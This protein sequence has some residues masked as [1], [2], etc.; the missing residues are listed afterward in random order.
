MN[1][2][3]IDTIYRQLFVYSVGFYSTITE[4]ATK[5]NAEYKAVAGLWKVFAILL[6][7]CCHIDYQMVVSAIEVENRLELE[8]QKEQ[9]GK[10]IAEVENAMEEAQKVAQ[11]M[12]DKMEFV[13]S[14]R[15]ME[16]R[17]RQELED[18][19]ASKGTGYEFEISM[20][21]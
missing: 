9:F 4:V 18:E 21:L 14:K 20:R 16:M 13:E 8:E 17:R 6:E 5:I 2:E 11:D 19:L 10:Q 15:Q 3:E 12:C 1:H 7:N